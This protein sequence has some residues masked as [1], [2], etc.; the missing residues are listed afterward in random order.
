M[1]EKEEWKDI[2][3]HKGLYQVVSNLG[4]I[5]NNKR[6]ILTGYTNN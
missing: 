5:R 6:R 1:F 2:I 4:R 3:T